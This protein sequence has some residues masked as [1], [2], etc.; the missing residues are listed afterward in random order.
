MWYSKSL[1]IKIDVNYNNKLDNQA[2]NEFQ[3][4]TS[5][6]YEYSDM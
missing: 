4:K 2:I 1:D 5:L 6:V 3:I